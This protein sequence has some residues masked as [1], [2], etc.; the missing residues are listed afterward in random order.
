MRVSY[1]VMGLVLLATVSSARTVFVKKDA[2][3]AGTGISWADAHA[4]LRT[5]IQAAVYGDTL[6][7]AAGTYKPT[8]DTNRNTAFVISRTIA[9]FGGFAG[10]ETDLNQ[11]DPAAHPAI[12][13]GDIGV[14]GDTS[15]NS[16]CV[17]DVSAACLIDGFRITGGHSTYSGGGLKVDDVAVTL[18]NCEFSYNYADYEG[19]AI[20]AGGWNTTVVTLE[21]CV[22]TGNS[23][24]SGVINAGSWGKTKVSMKECLIYGNTA[25][26]ACA[27][28]AGSWGSEILYLENCVIHSNRAGAYGG[29]IDFDGGTTDTLVL[30]NCTISGNVNG[31]AAVSIGSAVCTLSNTILW[32]EV[33]ISGAPVLSFCCITEDPMFV[34]SMR[35]DF[36]LSPLSP[37]IDAADGNTAASLDIEGNLRADIPSIANTGIGVLDFAD[38]GAYEFRI[39]PDGAIPYITSASEVTA[40]KGVLFTYAATAFDLDGDAV[41]FSF[42]GLPSWLSRTGD[43]LK[44]YVQTNTFD[45]LFTIVSF[46][47]RLRD[48]LVVTV[49]NLSA[50]IPKNGQWFIYDTSNGLRN[51]AVTAIEI[52]HLGNKWIGTYAGLHKLSG[53]AWTV[54]TDS[55]TLLPSRSISCVYEDR[56]NRLWVGTAS[57]GL[58]SLSGT[59][60]R[61]DSMASGGYTAGPPVHSVIQDNAGTVWVG[62]EG[63]Y[64]TS[65]YAGYYGNGLASWS[66]SAW[67]IYRQSPAGTRSIYH[68]HALARAP[69]GDLWYGL[70]GVYTGSIMVSGM[71]L[72]RSAA[73]SWSE[74]RTSG[75][76]LSA[77]CDRRGVAWLGTPSQGLMR[78]DTAWTNYRTYDGLIDNCVNAIA[79]DSLNNKW[80]GTNQG[81]CMR[82]DAG[83]TYYVLK[84]GLPGLQVNAIAVQRDTIWIGTN[85]G[86][87]KFVYKPGI[88][89]EHRS[90]AIEGPASMAICPNPFNPSTSIQYETGRASKGILEVLNVNGQKVFSRAVFGRGSLIWNAGQRP[91]GLYLCRLSVGKTILNK[92]MVLVK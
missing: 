2:S 29:V 8:A 17:I 37:C 85:N 63:E 76:Y 65:P 79:V 33:P 55:N 13:S 92:T 66:G 35:G 71:V 49:H 74:M 7:V 20:E 30:L 39:G 22:F 43:T 16:S 73:G 28:N 45:T 12:L 77:A 56:S 75:D 36:R 46:D 50:I 27:I 58:A 61:R 86:L 88:A 11:R 21:K 57:N 14:A 81:L 41:T 53:N 80:I 68:V 31:G 15:D 51:N 54:Y 59:T 62:A 25:E 9:T 19:S 83:W 60:W 32:E 4:E 10:A 69:N 67:T 64:R 87:A 5:A 40:T 1:I 52:D 82:D 90:A 84:D 70:Q 48:T 78:Y 18:R 89:V 24:G 23:G 34:D 44:G 42:P 26:N 47:G 72:K 38:I 6:W 3:G 91:S